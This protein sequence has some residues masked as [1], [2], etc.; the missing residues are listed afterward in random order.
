MVWLLDD[1]YDTKHRAY[2]M[3]EKHMKL[4]LLKIRSHGASSSDMPYDERYT[5][6]IQQLG[7]LPFITLVT[8]STPNLNAAA[9]T[10]LVDRWRLETHTFHLRT[11]EITPTFQDV[12]MIF[13]LPIAGNPLCMNTDSDGWCNEMRL[14]MGRA[15]VELEDKSKDRVPAGATYAW[16]VANFAH[17]PEPAEVEVIET[18]ARVYVWYVLSRTL[19]ADSGGRTA[20]WMWLKALTHFH[21]NISWGSVALAYL[22]R[23]LDDAC[24]RSSANAGIG[25]SMV[26]LSVWSWERL[27]VGRPKEVGY[28]P[29]PEFGR[30]PLRSPTWAYKWD[31][32]SEMTSDVDAMY[33][34][35]TTSSIRLCPSRWSGSLMVTGTILVLLPGLIL[36]RNAHPPAYKDTDKEL[37][38]L[39][40]KKQRKIKKWD[41]HHRK[42]HC[43]IAWDNYLRWF[44]ENTP[45]SICL[46]SYE[47]EILEE[48]CVFDEIDCNEYNKLVREGHGIPI[49]SSLNFARKEIKKHADE[50]EDILHDWLKGKKAEGILKNFLKRTAKKMRRLSNLL[51]CRDPEYTTPS[52]SRSKSI[53]DPTANLE[54][55]E[56]EEATSAARMEDEMPRMEN[57]TEE[58]YRIRSAYLLK[59]RR[60]FTSGQWRTSVTKGRLMLLNTSRHGGQELVGG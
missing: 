13:G 28:L 15:P 38:R 56:E 51:G 9:L 47:E 1:Y 46:P 19:F 17:Y 14:L 39:D 58:H 32:V 10:A 53:S 5:P 37:H 23:Q 31:V 55:D 36:T 44:L 45:V 33:M 6:Y 16:I 7:F 2:L 42:A 26:L 59:P 4:G 54:D 24:C 52:N 49:S 48:P 30:Q 60:G 29:W 50:T 18:H 20:Q 25:G 35:Y 21:S 34:K 12:S 8:R 57:E 11:G 40:R 3:A 22:Y 41:H 27:P 43:P